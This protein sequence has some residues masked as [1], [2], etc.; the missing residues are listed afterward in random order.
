MKILS[1]REPIIDPL[2]SIRGIEGAGAGGI[3]RIHCE[4]LVEAIWACS[5]EHSRQ[6]PCLEVRK[7]PDVTHLSM[8]SLGKQGRRFSVGSASC[9]EHQLPLLWLKRMCW[10]PLGRTA[11]GGDGL[12]QSRRLAVFKEQKGHLT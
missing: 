11:N 2:N 9:A 12:I 4:W 3:E 8:S 5:A 6:A 10:E 7:Q 1:G